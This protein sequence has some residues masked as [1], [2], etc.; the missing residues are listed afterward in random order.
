MEDF[1]AVFLSRDAVRRYLLY[2]CSL[3]SE[4]SDPITDAFVVA[5]TE[6]VRYTVSKHGLTLFKSA[7]P[8]PYTHMNSAQRHLIY[9]VV[10]SIRCEVHTYGP[11]AYA[12]NPLSF[13]IENERISIHIPPVK[14]QHELV[15]SILLDLVAQS[16]HPSALLFNIMLQRL[17][18]RV[19]INK[20]VLLQLTQR[21]KLISSE[22]T[23]PAQE[24]SRQPA[25]AT[26]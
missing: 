6:E 15:L 1:S 25:A 17:G 12:D 22:A 3:N 10:S 26:R 13:S 8:L 9:E 2:V 24:Q 23:A 7:S 18:N 5:M 14:L 11:F 20:D 21:C 4:S 19:Q 16:S